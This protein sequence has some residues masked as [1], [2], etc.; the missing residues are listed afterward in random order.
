MTYLWQKFNI[1]TFPSETIVFRNGAYQPELSSLKSCTIDK[2]YDLPV[3]IIYIGEIEGENNLE[4]NIKIPDQEVFL[5]ANT[6]NKNPAFL[7]IF[8]KNTGEK[9]FFN[10]KI[11]IENHSRLYINVRGYHS[12]SDTGIIILTKL[13][14]HAD[15]ISKLTGIAEIK[16]NCADCN[17]DIGFCALA[18]P[19]ARIEFAPK[20]FIHNIPAAA[21]HSASI[22]KGS[23]RQVEYLHEAGLS[24]AKTNAILT[25]AFANDFDLF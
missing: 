6:I 21:G 17:S 12:A 11:L 5:T 7:N 4:I 24:G 25:E 19:L 10:G 1:K 18:A 9:S 3:H 14:A 23:C 15:S 2:K 13:I 8:I 16:K 20:Q 22:Y